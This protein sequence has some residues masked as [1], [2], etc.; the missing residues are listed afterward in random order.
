MVKKGGK[1]IVVDNYVPGMKR[2][3]NNMIIFIIRKYGDIKTY[4]FNEMKNDAKRNHK[5]KYTIIN[6]QIIYLRR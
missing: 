6:G 5:N 2:H 1:V 4:S 3:I